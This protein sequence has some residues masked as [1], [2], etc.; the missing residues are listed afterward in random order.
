MK[1]YGIIGAI[2]G[3]DTEYTDD[4]VLTFV[5]VRSVRANDPNK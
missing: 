4:T 5:A 2:V 3:D 1:K